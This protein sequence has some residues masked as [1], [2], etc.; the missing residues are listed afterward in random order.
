MLAVKE[1]SIQ[2]SDEDVENLEKCAEVIQDIIDTINEEAPNARNFE[3][4]E[5]D[6][7]YAE[8]RRM[9]EILYH[10]CTSREINTDIT[11]Y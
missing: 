1:I 9:D 7:S 4:N 6:V 2:L 8:L 3:T 11:T 5:V 10:L